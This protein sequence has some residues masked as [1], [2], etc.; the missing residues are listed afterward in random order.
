MPD[1]SR[2][3]YFNRPEDYEPA[4]L[5]KHFSDRKLEVKVVEK[6]IILPARPIEGTRN[7]EGG[8]C[9]KDFKFIAGHHRTKHCWYKLESSYVIDKN[10]ITYLDEDVI[11]GGALM[12]HFGHFILECLTRLWYVLLPPPHTHTLEKVSKFNKK[13][14]FITTSHGGYKQWFDEFFRLMGIAKERIIYV[15]TPTQCRS[16]TVPERSMR[17]GKSYTKEYLIPFETIKANVSPAN[18]KKLY[19]S[20]KNF[21]VEKRKCFGE[22]YFDDFFAAH[23]FK[24]IE[25]EELSVEEQISLIMGADE[26]ASGTG[27]LTHFSLFCK[28]NTKFIMLSR[29]NHYYGWQILLNEATKID[30]YTI[31]CSRNFLYAQPAVGRVLFG[32]T[33]SWKEFV[34][35]YF[36]EQIEEDDDYLYSDKALEGY[37]KEWFSYYTNNPKLWY[38][39]IKK[40]CNR[41]VKLEKT[42]SSGRPLLTYQT[43]VGNGGWRTWKTENQLSNS[44]DKKRDIQAL[45]IGFTSSFCNVYYSVYYDEQEG[46]SEEVTSN[47]M[48][49]TTGKRKS[50]YGIKIRLD[51]IGEKKYDIIYRVHKFDGTW[52]DWAQNG[53]G[54]ISDQK[55]NSLQ[56]KLNSKR[57]FTIEKSESGQFVIADK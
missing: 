13:I 39:S 28:P 35:D 33:K 49:G 18:V 54:I 19:L 30:A 45:K 10:E 37:I 55:L 4:L 14:L 8:V 3:F 23:G 9:D 17:L 21:E 48:A 56:I 40:I 50:I 44:L 29:V 57:I 20:R 26:I 46:W 16:I 52:S 7:Y 27:T 42:V 2:R 15:D 5:K 41:I 43:H 38:S 32:A 51:E 34:A 36:D 24:S 53:E 11:F 31:D 12:G 47:Q 25:M 22:M 6:G 1:K